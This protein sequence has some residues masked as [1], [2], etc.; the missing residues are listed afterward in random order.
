M[1]LLLVSLVSFGAS[2]SFSQCAY[3]NFFVQNVSLSCLGNASVSCMNSGEYF[4][5]DVLQGNICT[6]STC[7]SSTFDSQLTTYDNTGSNVLADNDYA[8]GLQSTMSFVA[9]ANS[10][11]H[12]L[13]D[14]YNCL[15]NGG[16]CMDV[17]INCD[18]LV[19]VFPNPAV[20]DF[21]FSFTE[22][23]F[24]GSMKLMNLSGQI[25]YRADG[26]AGKG[27]QVHIKDLSS[28]IYYYT[29]NLDGK[30]AKGKLMIQ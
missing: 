11:V 5:L 10:S 3:N 7:G 18:E 25:I 4:S 16:S 9:S 26:I 21:N 1:R 30:F 12:V 17:T 15:N 27:C 24:K 8:R 6:I 14:R 22:S 23:I 29:F 13:L 19:Q 2:F 28:G 20:E